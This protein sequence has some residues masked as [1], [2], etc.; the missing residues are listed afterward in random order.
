[1]G[2]SL[3][4]QGSED[5]PVSLVTMKR[6]RPCLVLLCA[7]AALASGCALFSDYTVKAAPARAFIMAGDFASA[8]SVFPDSDASG[9]NE[10]LVRMERGMIL[11]DMGRYRESFEELDR[12][13][14]KIR[15]YEERAVIS[16]S[17][18]LSQAGT[19][20]TNEKAAP[21]EGEDYE[22]IM[23]HALGALDFLMLGDLESARV[24]VRRAYSRQEELSS[25]HARELEKAHKEVQRAQAADLLKDAG[26]Q[27]YGDIAKKASTVASA[28]HNSFASVVSAIVYELNGELDDAYIDMKKAYEAY[29]SSPYIA[30][31]LLRLS[32]KLGFREDHLA[33]RTRFGTLDGKED[34]GVRVVVFFSHGLAPV[35]VPVK[36]PI[37]LKDGFVFASVPVY[38]FEPSPVS[39]AVISA[40][41]RFAATS[42][43]LDVD[44]TAAR[45]LLDNFPVILAKQIVRSTLKALS[46]RG[47]RREHGQGGALLGTFLAGLTEQADLRTWSTLPKEIQAASL[48]VPQGLRRVGIRTV[49]RGQESI[50]EIPEGARVF[51]VVCRHTDAGL[52][53]HTRSY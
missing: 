16:A 15:Q 36:I 14:R 38:R 18:A 50:L 30:S 44:A 27:A 33:W 37:P 21:Y 42:T 47:L 19:I 6:I 3:K 23:I 28:Y 53:I 22:K 17:K 45:D 9:L 4:A 5:A 35:K 40:G 31:E 46:V 11:H 25:R 52:S 26:G 32:A 49:P 51:L 48:F 24:E 13:D 10:V 41:D 34:G 29:P 2:P 12:A 7:A 1:M 39:T 43:V 20:V 8:C